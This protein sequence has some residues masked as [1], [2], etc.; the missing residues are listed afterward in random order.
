MFPLCMWI[1]ME[2]QA[3]EALEVKTSKKKA[4]V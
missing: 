1:A 2:R 3:S 4:A